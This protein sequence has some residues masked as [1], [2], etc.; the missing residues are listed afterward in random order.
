[1]EVPIDYS[2]RKLKRSINKNSTFILIGNNIDGMVDFNF[3]EFDN[4]KKLSD[5]LLNI[6][7]NLKCCGEW[8][9]SL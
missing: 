6:L 3:R 1:M 8:D 5:E 7:S 4:F 9:I 2:E